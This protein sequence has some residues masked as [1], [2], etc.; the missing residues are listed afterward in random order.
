MYN[1][2]PGG[3]LL[4]GAA[5]AGIT[6][7]AADLAFRS[8][9]G[10]APNDEY[11]QKQKK[12]IKKVKKAATTYKKKVATTKYKP[13]AATAKPKIAA[14]K[15]KATSTTRRPRGKRNAPARR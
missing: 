13:K 12:K 14:T 11:N 3:D 9:Q 4:I 6:L 2:F 5:A 7:G 8:F 10:A 1:Q 15:P